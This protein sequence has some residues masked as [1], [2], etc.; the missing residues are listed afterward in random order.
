MQ[1]RQVAQL[2]STTCN[3]QGLSPTQRSTQTTPSRDLTLGVMQLATMRSPKTVGKNHPCLLAPRNHKI[4]GWQP[5]LPIGSK[6]PVARRMAHPTGAENHGADTLPGRGMRRCKHPRARF[7]E[8]Q[9]TG[10]QPC[11]AAARACTNMSAHA[12]QTQTG[13]YGHVDLVARPCTR[14]RLS[15]IVRKRRGHLQNQ[16]RGSR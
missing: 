15:F 11:K 4:E 12:S 13:T 6:E 7:D 8:L 16:T 9:R 14:E 3:L 5:P 10:L 2:R 1:I